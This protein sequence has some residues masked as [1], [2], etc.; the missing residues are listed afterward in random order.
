MGFSGMGGGFSGGMG[1]SMDS[2]AS[3]KQMGGF[4]QQLMGSFQQA[5]GY[6]QAAQAS[7]DAA[8]RNAKIV[9]YNAEQKL[10]GLSRDLYALRGQQIAAE[11]ASGFNIASMTFQSVASST[12]SKFERE[13]VGIKQDAKNQT[14]AMYFEAQSQADAYNTKASSALSTGFSTAF[15]NIGSLSGGGFGGGSSGGTSGGFGGF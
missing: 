3:F 14:D 12:L 9:V 15:N 11:G 8:E 13:V 2:S 5:A 10:T 4:T 6:N 7:L 1:S